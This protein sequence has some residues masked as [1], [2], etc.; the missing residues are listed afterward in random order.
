MNEGEKAV[1]FSESPVLF[2]GKNCLMSV[3][4]HVLTV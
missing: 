3:F 1:S 4:T 2:V